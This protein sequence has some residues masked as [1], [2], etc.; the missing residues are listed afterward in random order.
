METAS[1][2]AKEPQE[3]RAAQTT[4]TAQPADNK[5]SAIN[6][7]DF[8]RISQS[9]TGITQDLAAEIS[10]IYEA[11]QNEQLKEKAVAVYK[12]IFVKNYTSYDYRCFVGNCEFNAETKT[13][14][15]RLV[16]LLS[17]YSKSE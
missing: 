15:L 3:P 6:P 1:E 7:A 16:S 17:K 12:A 9:G 10:A 4:V 5:Y 14:L 8:P 2:P 13:F 11:E